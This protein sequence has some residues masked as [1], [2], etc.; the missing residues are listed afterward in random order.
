MLDKRTRCK[1]LDD[2]YVHFRGAATVAYESLS[3]GLW[4][5]CRTF[6]WRYHTDKCFTSPLTCSGVPSPVV[7]Q[8]LKLMVTRAFIIMACIFSGFGAILLVVIGII[9]K[10]NPRLIILGKVLVFVSLIFSIIGFSVGISWV[11]S[12]DR[13]LAVAAIL[14]IVAAG[15]NV[16]S[17]V[18]VLMI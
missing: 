3:V 11:L 12:S 15:L 8:C 13:Q 16:F 5:D 14:A 6:S 2:L 4:R 9:G 17:A 10:G 7:G 18:F 1:I